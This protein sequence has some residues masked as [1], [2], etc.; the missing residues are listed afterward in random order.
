[1]DPPGGLGK[2]LGFRAKGLGVWGEANYIFE[3]RSR[4]FERTMMSMIVIV[5]AVNVNH[6]FATRNTLLDQTSFYRPPK[7]VPL[8]LGTPPNTGTP[9]AEKC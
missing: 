6:F 5:I 8:L 1:M 7:V 4:I 2:G 3:N 9:K